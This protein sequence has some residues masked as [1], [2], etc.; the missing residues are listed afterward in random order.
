MKDKMLRIALT[1]IGI[2]NIADYFFTRRAIAAG[3]VESN[4]IMDA[5]LHTPIFPLYKLVIVTGFIF[6]IWYSRKRWNRLTPLI[7]LGIVVLVVAYS[8]VTIWHGFLWY[9][10]YV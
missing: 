9:S 8:G 3:M 7:T 5:I 6:F 10:G 2:F 1:I 4:P